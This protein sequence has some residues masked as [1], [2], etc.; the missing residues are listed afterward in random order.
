MPQLLCL[1]NFESQTTISK[2]N[3]WC[4]CE[5]NGKTSIFLK[6]ALKTLTVS[7][8]SAARHTLFCSLLYKIRGKLGRNR[9]MTYRASISSGRISMRYRS[10]RRPRL[11]KAEFA[12]GDGNF[13]PR[14]ARLLSLFWPVR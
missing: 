3:A 2:E 4:S 1:S 14:R 7:F 6:L 11:F 8:L 13:V 9:A 12:S 10:A 5:K